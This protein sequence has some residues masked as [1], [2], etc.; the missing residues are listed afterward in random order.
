MFRAALLTGVTLLCSFSCVAQSDTEVFKVTSPIQTLGTQI[1]ANVADDAEPYKS[2]VLNPSSAEAIL[3]ALGADARKTTIIHVLRWTDPEH[4]QT[5]FQKWYLYD[6]T[7]S[8]ISF[9]LQS[10]QQVFQSTAIPGRRDF[11]FIYIHLNADLGGGEGEWKLVTAAGTTL[12][13]PVSYTITVT[14]QQTQFLRDL[15]TVLQILGVVGAAAD[16]AKP[17]YYSVSTFKSQWDTSSISIAAS[18]DSGNKT[19]GKGDGQNSASNQLAS[20]TYANEKPSWIGLSA[21]VP[22]TKYKDVTFQSS[23]STLVPSSITKQDVYLFVDGYVP[24][25]LPSLSSFRYLPHPFFGL[26]IKGK[27]LRHSMLGVGIGLHW[28]E[29]FGGVIFDTENNEVKGPSVHKTQLKIQP[30]FGLKI[31]VSAVA[32]ALKGK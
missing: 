12:K 30:V 19:Q 4:T 2:G 16:V 21:G 24:P 17:G 29:P 9:Y 13:H 18:L 26:P 27:V 22:I 32:K 15:N 31:S 3:T 6:P 8:T 23:S 7:P 28:L 14:K 25:V 20:K 5:K 1:G 10:K 11:Q